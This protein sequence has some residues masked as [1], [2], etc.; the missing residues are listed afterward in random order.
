MPALPTPMTNLRLELAQRLFQEFYCQCFWHYRPD[1]PIT[2][3]RIP[4]VVKGLRAH[5][6]RKGL[7]AAAQLIAPEAS[8]GVC[9]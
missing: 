2:E 6:G 9:R 3:A 5:G 7:L 4:L 8:S 1:L